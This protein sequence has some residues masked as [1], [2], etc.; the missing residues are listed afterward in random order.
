MKL[1]LSILLVFLTIPLFSQ[2]TNNSFTKEIGLTSENDSYMLGGEDGYYTNG[3]EI[4]FNWKGKDSLKTH[5]ITAGQS[6]YNAQNGDFS[7][8]WDIDRP[9][10][11]YLYLSYEQTRFTSKKDLLHWEVAL[12]AIGPIAQGEEA[13]VFLHKML[14]FYDPSEEW[15]FQLNNSVGVNGEITWVKELPVASNME[16]QTI[17]KARAG[18]FFTNIEMGALFRWGKFNNNTHTAYWNT[19]INSKNQKSELFFYFQPSLSVYAYNATIQGGLFRDDKGPVTGKLNPF[20]YHQKIGLMGSW[21]RVALDLGINFQTK[22]TPS[23]EKAQWYGT[24]GL[25]YLL[26]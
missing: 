13:Q 25:K 26:R 4:Y 17:A 14:N 11:A 16:F 7:K 3:L 2:K 21:N 1:L 15:E 23:Q 9:V 22:E 19:R 8:I 6:I 10:T 12:G 5:S 18:F 24:I 20:L